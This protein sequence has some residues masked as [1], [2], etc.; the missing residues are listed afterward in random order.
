MQ[1]EIARNLPCTGQH[2]VYACAP[3]FEKDTALREVKSGFGS[4]PTTSL[5]RLSLS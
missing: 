3:P 4:H 1:K 2:L 5:L